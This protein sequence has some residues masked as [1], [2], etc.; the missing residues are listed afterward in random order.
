M[1]EAALRV[2]VGVERERRDEHLVRVGAR[3]GAGARV[4]IKVRI[5]VRVRVRVRVWLRARLRVK[6]RVRVRVRARVKVGVTSTMEVRPSHCGGS[7][8][9]RLGRDGLTRSLEIFSAQRTFRSS[10]RPSKRQK[11]PPCMG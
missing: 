9:P 11:V 4:R 5:R 7:S 1:R 6:V 8:R 2:Q 3:A 10:E